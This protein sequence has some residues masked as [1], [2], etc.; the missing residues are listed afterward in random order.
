ML[1]LLS[2]SAPLA[3]AEEDKSAQIKD[4]SSF[5]VFDIFSPEEPED[6]DEITESDILSEAEAA[7]TS[8]AGIIILRAINILSLLIGTFAFVMIIIGGFMFATA[9]GEE[10]KV[11]RGKA[12]LLQSIFGLIIAFLSYMIVTFIQSFFY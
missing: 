8:P 11:D 1:S 9:G 12:I 3:F 5:D 10:S 7:G 2:V 4:S 6:G